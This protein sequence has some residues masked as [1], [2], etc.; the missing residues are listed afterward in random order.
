M[1]RKRESKRGAAS[2]G[3]EKGKDYMWASTQH[4]SMWGLR[5]G[6]REMAKKGRSLLA[7]LTQTGTKERLRIADLCAACVK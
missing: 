3:G 5:M 1:Q 4:L 7:S 2:F 6:K